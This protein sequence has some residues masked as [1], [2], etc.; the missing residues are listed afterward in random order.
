MTQNLFAEAIKI[1]LS[2]L[3]KYE[4]GTIPQDASLKELVAKLGLVTETQL[5]LDPDLVKEPTSKQALAVITK[6][7]EGQK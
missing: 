3:Q 5:F 4:A 2:T 7:I 6:I 1:P